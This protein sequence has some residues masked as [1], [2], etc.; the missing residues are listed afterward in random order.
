M[1]HIRPSVEHSDI[2]LVIG[3]SST[4]NFSRGLATAWNNLV[5]DRNLTALRAFS[6]AELG[7]D[8]KLQCS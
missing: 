7:S 1:V 6:D 3:G 4:E 2:E 5:R 8:W